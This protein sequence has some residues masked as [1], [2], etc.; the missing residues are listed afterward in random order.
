[1]NFEQA[2]FNMIEQQIRS[3]E[4]LDQ[5]V[6]DAMTQVSRDQFVPAAYRTLAYSDTA[7][8]LAEGQE[9]MTPKLEGRA[10]QSLALESSDRVLEIGT[11]SAYL[12]ALLA[13]LAGHVTS[14]EYH[15]ALFDSAQQILKQQGFNNVALHHDDAI[16]GWRANEPYEAIVLT[17]SLSDYPAEI[18][19][20]L[21]IGG[22]MFVVVGVS[23]IM[24]ARLVTRVSDGEFSRESLFETDLI[25]LIGGE[26]KPK[27]QF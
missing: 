25:P 14:I 24:D 6:L 13:T 16:N 3:W 17:G 21:T 5:A 2:R 1:M 22:R 19:H 18:E 12:T 7:I 15:R 27:F 4:V 20:Q 9:M 10:V 11:G 8:P 23:P 26:A